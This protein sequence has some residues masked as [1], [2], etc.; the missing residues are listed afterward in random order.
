MILRLLLFAVIQCLFLFVSG[1]SNIPV[2]TTGPSSATAKPLP[3]LQL[4]PSKYYL[5]TSVPLKPTTDSGQVTMSSLVEDVN[6]S[7][8]YFDELGRPQQTVIKQASPAKNDYVSPVA[9]DEFGNAPTGYLPYVQQSGNTNDGKYKANSFYYDSVFYKTLFPNEQIYYG[10]QSYDGSPLQRTTKTTAPGNSWTGAGKG[11]SYMQRANTLADSVRLWIIP[12]NN[13]ND[14]PVTDSIFKAGTLFVNET[15]DERGIKTVVYNDEL[16]RTVLTKTQLAA[17][18]STGHTGWLCTYYVFD[19]M[20]HVRM[21]LPPKAVEVL[22][23]VSVN[24]NLTSNSA[25]V[26]GLCYF[27]WFDN[28]G[29]PVMK[30]IPG[31]GK[32]YIAYDLLGR[33]VMTQDPNL[34]QTNQ[35]AFAKYDEQNR[36]IKSGVITSVLSKDSIIAQA[37]RSADYPVLTG[38]Y[39]V[40]T[41]AYYD[42]YSW[43]ASSGSGLTGSIVTTNIN[44]TNFYTTYNSSPEYAQ[45]ITSS[46][47][48]RGAVTGIKK[49]IIGSS[50]YLFSLNIYDDHG[51][52]IQTKQTNYTSG[53]DIITAQY[54]FVG[55][56]LRTHVQH[57]KSGSNSQ[58]HTL[59]T[60]YSYDHAGRVKT[61]VKNIDN[62]EDKTVTQNT[63]NELGQLQAKVFGTNVETQNFSYNI[64]GWLTGIN[65]DYINTAG[66]TSNFFGES[67]FYDFGFTNNQFNGAI[68]GVKWKAAGD[69]TAR[70]YGFTYDNA[71]RL[72]IADFS[73]QNSGSTSWTNDKVDFSVSGLNYDAGSNILSMK[74]KGLKL[75]SPVTIDSLT[76]QYFTN[77][78][79]LQKVNDGITDNSPLGDF[80]DTTFS[81]DDYS[82]DINGNITKDYNR[83][84]HTSS[85]GSGAV[86]NYLDKPDSLVI[87]GKATLYYYYDVSGVKLRKKVNDY[88]GGGA[89]VV[90]DYLYINGFVYL[91]DTL[92]YVMQEEG[93]IRYAKKKNIQTGALYYAFEY[94]YFLRDHLGNVRTVLTEGRDTSIYAATMESADS[95]IVRATFSNVYDPVNTVFAKPSSFDNDNNNNFV[96]KL[97]A[98]SA[99]NKKTGPSLVL[100]VMAGDQVQ[101]NTFAYYN[102]PVQSPDPGVDLSTE[103]LNLLS[104]G[105]PGS[106]GG[107][108]PTGTN[109]NTTLNPGVLQFLNNDRSY[110]NTKPKAYLNWILFDNQ[111]NYVASNS[112]VQQVQPGS[113]KQALI[114]SLQTIAKNG[115]LYIYVSNESPQDVYFDDLTVKH[116][117]GPLLQEQAYYP[118]GLQMAG[119]SDKAI[120]KL[121]SQYKF[122]GGIELEEDYGVNLYSTFFRQYDPQLGRFSGVDLLS[123]EMSNFS[124]YQFGFNN[125]VLFNDPFGDKAELPKFNNVAELLNYIRKNG[126]QNFGDYMS[127]KFDDY[128]GILEFK[129]GYFASS[130]TSGNGTPG[131]Y[132]NYGGY[133][134]GYYDIKDGVRVMGEVIVG[135]MFIPAQD[136]YN[137]YIDW[138][139]ETEK[140]DKINMGMGVFGTAS[141]I[142]ETIIE[143]G[144]ALNRGI[145][146]SR[147]NEFSLI[148]TY[149]VSGAKYLK[150][151]K[152]LGVVGSLVTTG[153]AVGKVI[154]QYNDAGGWSNVAKHRDV[155]DAGVGVVGLGATGLAA[156]GIISN[157]VGW[158]IGLGV[159]IYGGATLIYDAVND[160]Q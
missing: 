73:Q 20:N 68:A 157:P 33:V 135:K 25:I 4:V 140:W 24:W 7:T 158:C 66:S 57:Q 101:I 151:S 78:N 119:I 17:S 19:E 56:V 114:A 145:N 11:I 40:T 87:A 43:V 41:E 154:D 143:G 10:Q 113:S 106:S 92:Q 35:W 89:A 81:G 155:W 21:V 85:N 29:R 14:I 93:R 1:Q 5:R 51:R 67:L 2:T 128:G 115:Y 144:A 52:V 120:N 97:N 105:I 125:P 156:V 46:S 108:I 47:R 50:N 80:K 134:S 76:Y 107:K 137:G 100:K 121:S 72:T 30:S 28:L 136:F 138:K 49:L 34:R 122:N 88:T 148:R 103:L 95:A 8:R 112:G 39:T 77:S 146:I 22:N 42:D 109:L 98:S 62:L 86:Y 159:L 6:I 53:I 26:T 160:D 74:Q 70:A 96:S 84:M 65:K 48:I 55:R 44:S 117:T 91:N 130:G 129:E 94:D 99:V 82:Y 54:S 27:Y 37:A 118:F 71:N 139:K 79:Q 64:R 23:T 36:G 3:P 104:A 147:V 13:E 38:T 69:G 61:I 16:G 124:P 133:T 116:Y 15:T 127:W 152:T 83:H 110:D 142:K 58:T 90:K 18:P 149:G 31:K 45:S 126:I 131:F 12:I 63:F 60:K 102:T 123:E 111:F 32:S 9:I 59:L 153:Y 75:G 132:V 141:G 150:I